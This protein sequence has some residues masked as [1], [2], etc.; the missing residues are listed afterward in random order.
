MKEHF[1]KIIG[2]SIFLLIAILLLVYLNEL[3]FYYDTS[4]WSTDRRM[5]AYQDLPENSVDVLFLGSSHIMSGV[6]PVQLWDETGIQAYS[7]C[8]RAQSLPFSYGYLQDA[9]KTQSPKY[10][11]LD[12]SSVFQDKKI[13]NLSNSEV[14]F[15][16]NMDN[17]STTS[18]AE[19]ITK[20]VPKKE[21]IAYY[22]P[23]FKNHSLLLDKPLKKDPGPIFMGYC[24]VDKNTVLTPPDYS[25]IVS[26]TTDTVDSEYF[27]KIVDLCCKKEIELIV[28]KTPCIVSNE[29]YGKLSKIELL[30]QEE[31][32]AFLDMNTNYNSFNF[33]YTTDMYDKLHIN[34]SGA[35]KI[36]TYLGTFLSSHNDFDS[37]PTHQYSYIW[38]DEYERMI[39][40]LR[41]AQ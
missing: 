27:K 10:V 32:I 4:I 12:A 13:H 7:Y 5:C 26:T 41:Q 1:K 29:T 11:V 9:L 22:F 21:W 2:S 15:G 37:S 33:D 8:S 16:I 28:I 39:T 17:L 18:K 30:C 35:A 6:N 23:L 3:L 14:H 34:S 19:L 25:N 40:W 31:N 20:Y 24:F 36:T 38:S